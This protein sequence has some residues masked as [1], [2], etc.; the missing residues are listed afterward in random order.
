MQF[1]L[2]NF[3][4]RN[5]FSRKGMSISI[6]VVVVVVVDAVIVIACDRGIFSIYFLNEEIK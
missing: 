6:V 5:R 2:F 4:H 3:I 1:I